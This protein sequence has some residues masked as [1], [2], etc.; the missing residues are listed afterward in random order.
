MYSKI[1]AAIVVAITSM[2]AI[3]APTY[4]VTFKG[5]TPVRVILDDSGKGAAQSQVK[6][7]GEPALRVDFMALS[8][9]GDVLSVEGEKHAEFVQ[10]FGEGKHTLSIPALA[11]RTWLGH[12]SVSPGK[13]VNLFEQGARDDKP[14]LISIARID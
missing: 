7:R 10:E 3:A 4:E 9:T 12:F 14:V 1:I 2:S 8:A 5:E 11:I 6:V 13:P